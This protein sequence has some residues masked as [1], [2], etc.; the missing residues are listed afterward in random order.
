MEQGSIL[1]GRQDFVWTVRNAIIGSDDGARDMYSLSNII[2]QTYNND[3]FGRVIFTDPMMPIR[4][5]HSAS[6]K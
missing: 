6:P 2:G 1:N 5:E 4:M 3:A